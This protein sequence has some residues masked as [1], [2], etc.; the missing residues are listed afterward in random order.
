MKTIITLVFTLILSTT[1][2]AIELNDAKQQKLV[3]ENAQGYLTLI[4]VS[5]AEAAVLVVDINRKRKSKYQ[6]IA[7]RQKAPLNHIEHIAGEKLTAKAKAAGHA[8][9][10]SAGNWI[11]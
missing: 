8:Y 11:K 1:A 2:W 9:Q 6:E 10:D 4:V 7:N 3:G 5:N